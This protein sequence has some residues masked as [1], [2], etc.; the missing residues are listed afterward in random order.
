METDYIEYE[1]RCFPRFEDMDSYGILHHS[2]YLL[3]V[4]EAK[5]AFMH[6]PQYFGRD[7]LEEEAKFLISKIQIAYMHAIQY[8]V[9]VPVVVKLRFYI[10]K[11]IRIIFDFR[12]Y[13]EEKLACRGRATHIATDRN[14]RLKLELPDGLVERYEVL[15]G[16]RE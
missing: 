6:D 15:K 10:E 13:Y 3:L 11:D 14:N 16:G 4:E 2:R 9:G 8:K 7:V 12:I 1:H 5:L